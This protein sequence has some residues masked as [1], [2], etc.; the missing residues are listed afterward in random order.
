MPGNKFLGHPILVWIILTIFILLAL[1]G[2]AT[3]FN[4]ITLKE[5]TCVGVG[6]HLVET[7]YQII[8]VI[9]KENK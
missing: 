7:N 8:C 2:A 3:V 5:G 9:D 1:L 4:A 6:G